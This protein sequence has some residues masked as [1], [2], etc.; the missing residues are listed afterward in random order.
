M[1][2]VGNATVSRARQVVQNEPLEKDE[3]DQPL[4]GKTRFTDFVPNVDRCTVRTKHLGAIH[5][6]SRRSR[7]R[8]RRPKPPP[9][10]S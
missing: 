1:M 10:S 2:G 5:G 4:V 9:M 6:L 7:R 8:G 3:D